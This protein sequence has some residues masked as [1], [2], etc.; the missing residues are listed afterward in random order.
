MSKQPDDGVPKTSDHI[1]QIRDIIFGPQKREYD[2]RFEQV[3]AE[4]QRSRNE[5][6]ARADEMRDRLEEKITSGLNA[7]DQ[8][9]RQLSAK[10]QAETADLQKR[11]QRAEEKLNT[12]ITA[13]S[14]RVDQNNT[15]LRQDLADTRSRL[16]TEV[17]TTRDELSKNLDVQS[18][19]L[20]ETKVSR[21]VMAEMLQEVAM[22]LR[23][24]EVL[25]ELKKAAR[26]KP[27]D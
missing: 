13:L 18:S 19:S 25:E 7:L 2:E 27:G 5:F 14:Q 15:A 17:R 1:E 11:L 10:L 8:G 9:I 21:D 23:G 26:K 24:V 6:S 20:R 16:Q 22:K 4:L 12:D 3:I